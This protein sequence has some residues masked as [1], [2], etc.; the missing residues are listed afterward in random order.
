MM[1]LLKS[2]LQRPGV[3]P[4]YRKANNKHILFEFLAGC[5]TVLGMIEQ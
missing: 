3:Y 1:G 4:V 2:P 5:S